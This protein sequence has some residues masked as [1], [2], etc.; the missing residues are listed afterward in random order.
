ME[1]QS[2]FVATSIALGVPRDDAFAA[3]DGAPPEALARG[4]AST[5]RVTRAKA[6]AEVLGAVA[7]DVAALALGAP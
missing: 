5:S 3:I 4:L 6:L 1:W 2:A 7:R